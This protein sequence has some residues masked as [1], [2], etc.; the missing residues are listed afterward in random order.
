MTSSLFL[1]ILLAT[2]FAI[3]LAQNSPTP[4]DGF[5]IYGP[6]VLSVTTFLVA[7]LFDAIAAWEARRGGAAAEAQHPAGIAMA[8]LGVVP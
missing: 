5:T 8:A 6:I 1:V 4:I 7:L 3:S 2:Y